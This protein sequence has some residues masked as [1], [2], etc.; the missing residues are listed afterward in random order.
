MLNEEC[1]VNL[2]TVGAPIIEGDGTALQLVSQMYN[3]EF[4]RSHDSQQG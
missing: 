4:T 1:A 2:A 3:S